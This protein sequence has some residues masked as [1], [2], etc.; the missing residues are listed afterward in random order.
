M[1]FTG[2]LEELLSVIRIIKDSDQTLRRI[3]NTMATRTEL[4][5]G[6]NA[7]LASVGTLA[8]EQAA[9]FQRL[10]D[11]IAAG[12]DFQVELDQVNKINAQVQ[13]LIAAAQ[14]QV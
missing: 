5:D 12:G 2:F 11:K 9:A 8:T 7:V 13:A 1:T 3:E 6:I 4:N 10:L 14:A